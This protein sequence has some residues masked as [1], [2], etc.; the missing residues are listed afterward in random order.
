[1]E[2]FE[3]EASKLSEDITDFVAVECSDCE[4]EGEG[5]FSQKYFWTKPEIECDATH[6]KAIELLKPLGYSKYTVFPAAD[7]VVLSVSK[8][9][10]CGSEDII[11]D[12]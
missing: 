4:Y 7:V 8:C 9:P 11:Q 12:Y 6:D 10:K 3:L 5:D 1:M 2:I